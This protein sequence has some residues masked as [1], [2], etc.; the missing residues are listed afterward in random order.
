[1]GTN[2]NFK[3]W[4]IETDVVVVGSGAAGLCAANVA[5]LEGA[6]KVVV[7]EKTDNDRWSNNLFWRRA[8][9]A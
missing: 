8:V 6:K 3:K 7:L 4:D 9:G 1:M 5:A 2:N